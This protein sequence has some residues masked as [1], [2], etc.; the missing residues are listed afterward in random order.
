MN[1]LFFSLQ[2][3]VL[4]LQVSSLYFF[5]CL[6]LLI[7]FV[8]VTDIAVAK[9]RVR[10]NL[11][12]RHSSSP[13]SGSLLQMENTKWSCFYLIPAAWRHVQDRLH[14]RLKVILMLSACLFPDFLCAVEEPPYP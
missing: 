10:T 5:P 1:F 13:D 8:N 9:R 6:C 14:R 2:W 3:K 4:I 11:T 12:L 7:T